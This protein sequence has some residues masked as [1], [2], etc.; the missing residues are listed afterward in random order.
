VD[1]VQP[2]QSVVQTAHLGRLVNLGRVGEYKVKVSRKDPE[3]QTVVQSNEITLN[4]I[5]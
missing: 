5:P 1:Y 4:V 3:T 2:G